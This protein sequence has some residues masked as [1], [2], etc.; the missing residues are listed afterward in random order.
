MSKVNFFCVGV[1][2][3]GTTTLHNILSQ[4]PDLCLPEKKETHFF[5][6]EDLYRKGESHYLQY[7]NHSK[8]YKYFGEIDPEYSYFT[9]SAERIFNTYG[10]I[11][12]LFILRNPVDRAY[13]HYLMTKRR[14][15]ENLSFE[16]AMYKEEGRINNKEDNMHYSYR[17]RGYYLDQILNYEKYF[18][19][20]NI[21]VL[22]FD[23]F[24]N[25]T[26][27]CILDIIDFIGLKDFDFNTETIS[28]PA[29]HPRS[30]YLQK[31][32]Y[33]KNIF[34]ELV[35]N[36]IQSKETKRRIA[37]YIEKINLKTIEKENLS[38]SLRAEIY[39]T[40]YK[41]QILELERK[42]NISLKNWK[43]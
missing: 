4:H 5:S 37:E 15:L 10:K 23:D 35:G 7:F 24:T 19:S 26:K 34:K 22:L 2:K 17:S 9:Q 27:D 25:N 33:K 38:S 14:G 20:E 39:N 1:Q 40:Y 16:N 8:P 31:I 29:S 13:S 3:A 6:N 32:L 43:H 12:I 11:K 36:L 21:K 42:L 30:G 18:G 41:K 28:N